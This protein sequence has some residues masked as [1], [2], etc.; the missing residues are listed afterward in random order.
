MRAAF[1]HPMA[2]ASANVFDRHALAAP[3]LLPRP[4]DALKEP[5]IVLQLI[6]V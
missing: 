1:R 5:R 4:R 3:E 2:D 6:W